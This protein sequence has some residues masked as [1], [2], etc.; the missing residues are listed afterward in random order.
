MKKHINLLSGL[1][2]AI[3]LVGVISAATVFISAQTYRELA[4]DFQRQ[5]MARLVE[6]KVVDLIDEAVRD[7]RQLGVGIQYDD[8]FRSAYDSKDKDA[9]AAVLKEQYRRAP[10]SPDG[11][12]TVGLSVFDSDLQP[13]ASV[14]RTPAGSAVVFCPEL[15]DGMRLHQGAQRF[16][17]AHA[18]C[19]GDGT[20]FLAAIAPIGGKNPTGY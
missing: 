14:K 1:V 10:I 9:I 13:L 16:Q 8:R 17:P 4:F 20:P 3:I 6:V 7:A 19:M 2:I 15:I 11:L 18:L 12:E 5:S